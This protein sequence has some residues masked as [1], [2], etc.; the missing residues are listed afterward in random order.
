MRKKLVNAM[1]Y[2]KVLVIAMQNSAADIIGSYNAKDSFPVPDVFIPKR[3]VDKAV[4]SLFVKDEDMVYPN[5][6]VK[7][8]V[9]KEGFQV[10]VTSQ[11]PIEDY[12]EFLE[13][14]IPLKHC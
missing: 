12:K 14:A 11:F 10:V 5:T 4:W 1:K 6:N 13:T 9:V 7:I 8:F 2:G 3:I